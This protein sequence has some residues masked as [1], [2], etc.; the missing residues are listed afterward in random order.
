[1]D[2]RLRDVRRV[3]WKPAG[4]A[5]SARA[6]F[7]AWSSR[8]YW[9]ATCKKKTGPAIKNE[10]VDGKQGQKDANNTVGEG[11]KKLKKMDGL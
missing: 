3:S 7:L 2:S 11:V 6:L 5:P 1:M 8:D 10:V 9:L 4:C